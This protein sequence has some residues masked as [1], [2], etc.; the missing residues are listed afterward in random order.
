MPHAALEDVEHYLEAHV[1]VGVSHA[2]GRDSRDVHRQ[3]LRSD[4]LTRQT[5]LVPNAVPSTYVAAPADCENALSAF[6]CAEF[7]P[8]VHD[9]PFY[10]SWRWVNDVRDAAC[11]V[12]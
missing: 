8:V 7:C 3:F 11:K 12:K 10:A 6:H 9:P 2:A 1:D 5:R 4:I